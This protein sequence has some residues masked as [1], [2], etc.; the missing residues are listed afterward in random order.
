VR[1]I[2]IRLAGDTVGKGRARARL[3]KPKR[4]AAFVTLYT[5]A[6]TRKFEKELRDAADLEMVRG[7]HK[8]LK[9]PLMVDVIVVK[10]VPK[11]WPKRTRE[12]ALAGLVRPTGKPDFDNYAKAAC[13]ALNPQRD[14]RTGIL[15]G[16]IWRDDAEVVDG[17]VA[18]WYGPD[19]QTGIEVR[20]SELDEA[21]LCRLADIPFIP[22]GLPLPEIAEPI[23]ADDDE[24]LPPRLDPP[25]E[26]EQVE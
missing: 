10:P 21:D 16:G 19:D 2:V 7:R 26:V 18:K 5:P 23:E 12:L 15:A 6:K 4:G 24:E 22:G 20:A 17:R 9:G 13:D 25:D 14:K 3:V 11:S 8:R 1:T